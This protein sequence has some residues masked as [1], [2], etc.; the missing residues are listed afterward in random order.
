MP[1]FQFPAGF[2]WG[3]AASAHQVEGHN[4]NNDW[5]AWEQAG[6][7]KEPSGAACDHYHRYAQDFDLAAEMGH[8]AHRFSIEWSR[9][10]PEE[11]RWDAAALAHY[12]DV[13]A[14][15]RQRKLEPVVTLHHFTTPQW[16]A[17]QGGWTNRKIVER[18]G[19]YARKI[20]ETLGQGVR[21]WAPINEPM[22]HV[23][24]HFIQGLGPPGAK[25]LKQGLAVAENLIRAH[26]AAYHALRETVPGAQIGIAHHIPAFRPCKWWSPMDRWATKITDGIFNA[27]MLNAMM[28]GCWRVPAVG[29]FQIPEAKRTLDFLGVNYYGRQFVHWVPTLKDWPAQTCDPADHPKQVTERTSLGW[30]VSPQGLYEVLTE[31]AKMGLPIFVT[32]NGTYM[33]DDARREA[34]IVNHIKAVARA[35]QTGVKITGYL[36][37]SLLDNF[38]WAEG[39][40]PRFGIVEVDYPTQRRT[41]RPSGRRYAEICK[42]NR[43]ALD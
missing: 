37:W 35:M 8:R 5:W 3:S 15:L 31:Y 41:I 36:Y 27:A 29:A 19:R 28:D 26:A 34:F 2:L 4:T 42:A 16:M 25:D 21:Y 43:I 9:I 30:D 24:M 6:K 13:L 40:G 11:G 14:A 32:E 23:R 10:E 12:A 7:V 38:E 18:F 22:V 20:G 1:D 33:K 17:N 39:Y